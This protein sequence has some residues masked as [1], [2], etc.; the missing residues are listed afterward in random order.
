MWTIAAALPSSSTRLPTANGMCR[1]P[2]TF[3]PDQCR[4][5]VAAGPC[6]KSVS[7]S[8]IADRAA[9]HSENC[10]ETT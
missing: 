7:F 1:P 6:F 8:E 5:A 4:T 9:M 10:E 3:D 2:V